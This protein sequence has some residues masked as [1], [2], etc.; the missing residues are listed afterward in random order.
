MDALPG[1]L[2]SRHPPRPAPGLSPAIMTE[3]HHPLTGNTG[4]H[5]QYV[6]LVLFSMVTTFKTQL[7]IIQAQ[8]SVENFHIV[9]GIRGNIKFLK[10]ITI[11]TYIGRLHLWHMKFLRSGIESE[12]QL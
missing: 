7:N 3:S 2:R 11:C 1:P 9:A 6:C 8:Q 5:D 10:M 4:A 12:P